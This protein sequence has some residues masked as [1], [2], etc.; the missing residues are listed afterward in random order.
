M[1]LNPASA[2]GHHRDHKT[3][4]E[5]ISSPIPT[6][7]LL[8]RRH[9]VK[10]TLKKLGFKA[11]QAGNAVDAALEHLGGNVELEQLIREALKRAPRGVG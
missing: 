9:D 11:G 2:S 10:Q 6:T 3:N 8:A 5:P 4:T 7:D 1:G